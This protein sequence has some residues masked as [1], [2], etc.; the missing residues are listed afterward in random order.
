M[1]GVHLWLFVVAVETAVVGCHVLAVVGCH[2]VTVVVLIEA[3]VRCHVLAVVTAV[4]GCH[5]LV[6]VTAVVGCHVVTDVVDKAVAVVADRFNS[7]FDEFYK[8]KN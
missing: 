2:V 1:G 5:V 7:I 4:V 6:V 8:T 3:V